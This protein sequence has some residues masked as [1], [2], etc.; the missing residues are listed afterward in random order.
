MVGEGRYRG[1]YAASQRIAA[2]ILALVRLRSQLAASNIVG[3]ANY[4]CSGAGLCGRFE[5]SIPAP[6][7]L[8][9]PMTWRLLPTGSRA[10]S[11]IWKPYN[12]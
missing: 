5:S 12:P 11:L 8:T 2:M 1:A 4:F 10:W 7:T 3:G 9:E 6:P